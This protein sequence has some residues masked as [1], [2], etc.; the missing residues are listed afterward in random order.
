MP[1]FESHCR[2]P[3]CGQCDAA[4]RLAEAYKTIRTLE[5]D[6]RSLAQENAENRERLAEA[7]RLLRDAVKWLGDNDDEDVLV[8]RIERELGKSGAAK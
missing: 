1:N 5:V 6:Y 3:G 4:A 2:C 7:E 8:R